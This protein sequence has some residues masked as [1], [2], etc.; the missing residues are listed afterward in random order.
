M[1]RN[2]GLAYLYVEA[3]LNNRC[4]NVFI[5]EFNWELIGHVLKVVQQ[6]TWKNIKIL[7]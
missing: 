4:S 5:A 2:Q 3:N 1:N 7:S 6:W